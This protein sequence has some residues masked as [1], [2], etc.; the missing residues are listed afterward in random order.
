[1]NEII[2]YRAQHLE[3]LPP[4]PVNWASIVEAIR[5]ECRGAYID[6]AQKAAEVGLWDSAMLYYWNEAMNDLRQKVMAYGI[7]YFPNPTNKKITDKESLRENL[8]DYELIEGCY[9]LG[10]ISKEAWFFLQ[11]ARGIRNHYTAAHLSESQIDMMEALNFIKNC[12]KYV[13]THE[14]PPPGF[15][16]RDFI[17]RLRNNDIRGMV[18]EIETAV[19][20]QASEIRITLLNRLF[21]EYVDVGCSPTFR[22][23]IEAIAPSVWNSVDKSAQEELGQRYI[24]VRVGPSQD[25]ALLAFSF[26]KMVN[27][28]VAI[29]EAYRCPIF[30]SYANELINAHFGPNNFY[31]EDGPA[32]ALLELGFDVPKEVIQVYVKAVVLSF[33]GNAFGYCWAAEAYNRTIISHFSIEFVRAFIYLLE[34]DR[35]VQSELTNETPANRLKILISII[36]ERPTLLEHGKKLTFILNLP[37]DKITKLFFKKVMT[38]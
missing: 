33:I 20:G 13:L 27:G 18:T 2:P 30:Q 24:K 14:P 29:P 21:S 28:L 9:Q 12:V 16:I 10:V 3:K 15:S 38:K 26:F 35:D 37:E 4:Q 36:L 6:K 32:K 1:M 11:Q 5:P 17:E 23:N 25:S 8:N 19:R 22:A 31:R 7:E 34:N